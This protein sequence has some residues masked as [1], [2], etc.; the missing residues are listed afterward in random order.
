[1][2]MLHLSTHWLQMYDKAVDT[3][4][5]SFCLRSSVNLK[6]FLPIEPKNGQSCLQW[7]TLHAMQCSPEL[8]TLLNKI[9]N[10]NGRAEKLIQFAET[11]LYLDGNFSTIMSAGCMNLGKRCTGHWNLREFRK[12]L[13]EE[14]RNFI[15]SLLR[16]CDHYTFSDIHNRL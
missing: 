16:E 14:I 5:V 12:N 3:S 2:C 1:M 13:Q 10:K 11:F 7:K 9:I 4:V 6:Y 8:D 15:Q